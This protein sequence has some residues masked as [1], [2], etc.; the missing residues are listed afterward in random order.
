MHK[1][2]VGLSGGVDSALSAAL[3]KEEGHNVVGC[4]IKIWQPEFIDCSWR[5]DRLDAMRV[6]AALE[7]PFKEV[8]LSESY[9]KDVIDEMVS[10]YSRGLTPNP[11]VLCNRKIKFGLFARWAFAHG[12]DYIATG[13]YAQV[14]HAP[15][16][17]LLRGRDTEK[18]QSYFLWQ[19]TPS[20]L[21]RTFFPVGHLTKTMVR[22]EARA[23]NLP[24]AKKPDSQG[25]CFVGDIELS[26]FLSHYI[27]FKKGD[28]LDMR[29]QVVGIHEGAGLYTRGQRHGFTHT[30]REAAYVVRTD[31]S[32]NTVTVSN[33][34]ADAYVSSVH[35]LASNWVQSKTVPFES[36]V[37]VRYRETPIAAR[38]YEENG[39]IVV[40]FK[41][42]TI[43]APGQS[44]VWYDNDAVIGGGYIQMAP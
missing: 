32:A 2:F 3:L 6:C 1:V 18:D 34:S 9:K 39:A 42:N 27:A 40:E 11:D 17:R 43:A 29:G 12:A 38:T 24:V 30:G 8:D 15:L 13:H 23:R 35:V 4:F 14:E 28:V 22:K 5:E 33:S 36:H 7:I 16:P 19:L 25:L 37:Q 21:A 10:W 44:L 31:V 26:E 41:N 20:D